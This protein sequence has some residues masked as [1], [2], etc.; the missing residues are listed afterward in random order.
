M[1]LIDK[2]MLDNQPMDIKGTFVFGVADIKGSVW[3]QDNVPRL[4]LKVIPLKKVIQVR[5]TIYR[6][7]ADDCHWS[8][9][10]MTM[11]MLLKQNPHHEDVVGGFRKKLTAIL[12]QLDLIE[13]VKGINDYKHLM[14][15]VNNRTQ[16]VI[17]ATPDEEWPYLLLATGEQNRVFFNASFIPVS[18][19]LVNEK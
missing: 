19:S 6:V 11:S 13:Q 3:E 17:E 12:S 15:V 18:W 5:Q 9:T 14:E 4:M 10:G 16:E 2:N 7:V 8:E 1:S